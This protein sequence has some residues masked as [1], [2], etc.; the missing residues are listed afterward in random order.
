MLC[1]GISGWQ[2]VTSSVQ[3]SKLGWDT[4]LAER[5][6]EDWAHHQESSWLCGCLA[7]HTGTVCAERGGCFLREKQHESW[8]F[9]IN[10]RM[11][12]HLC[13][14]IKI[15]LGSTYCI[16][17]GSASRC[18]EILIWQLTHFSWEEAKVNTGRVNGCSP[19]ICFG[20]CNT[21]KRFRTSEMDKS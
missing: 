1:S 11:N 17:T 15:I 12:F 9:R 14:C 19:R 5:K 16:S 20:F 3:I 4:P 10:S 8:P 13:I 21:R 6:S 18:A 2:S 7:T